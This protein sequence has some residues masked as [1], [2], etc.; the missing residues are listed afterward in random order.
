MSAAGRIGPHADRCLTF[1]CEGQL[2]FGVWR[3][4]KLKLFLIP[5]KNIAEKKKQAIRRGPCPAVSLY[6]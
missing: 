4:S 2:G 5:E 3:Q 6:V 1:S